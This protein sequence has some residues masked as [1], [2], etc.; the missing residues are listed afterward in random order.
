M[1]FK[2]K[3]AVIIHVKQLGHDATSVSTGSS[4][5]FKEDADGQKLAL[6]RDQQLN[7][8]DEKLSCLNETVRQRKL[9]DAVLNFKVRDDRLG[10]YFNIFLPSVIVV[11]VVTVLFICG[12]YLLMDVSFFCNIPKCI[13][14]LIWDIFLF[15]RV[16]L[17]NF[18]V[19]NIIFFKKN[20]I[21]GLFG[22]VSVFLDEHN[23]WNPKT[24]DVC[25]LLNP[26]SKTLTDHHVEK[27]VFYQQ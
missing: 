4:L 2:R 24:A 21:Y 27:L 10:W 6:M 13:H 22:K 3:P 9:P 16:F 11:T 19:W 20:D 12:F 23:L 15:T 17:I 5:L 7:A 1:A 8:E 26:H 25:A 14:L 18:N